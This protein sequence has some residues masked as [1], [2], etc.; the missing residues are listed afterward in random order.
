MNDPS[1]LDL[2]NSRAIA[3]LVPSLDGAGVRLRLVPSLKTEAAAYARSIGISFN[4]LCAVALRDY[5]D[6]R[7]GSAVAPPAW[8]PARS[9]ALP[10][11]Q[12]ASASPTA[13]SAPTRKLGPNEKCY[14]GSGKKYK[15]CHGMPSQA[16]S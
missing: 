8:K 5:L 4:A 1:D 2:R 12:A 3:E 13:S 6:A 16:S 10:P 15:K 7:K 14:C 11:A 9:I